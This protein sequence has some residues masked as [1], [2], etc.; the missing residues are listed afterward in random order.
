MMS[1]YFDEMTLVVERHGGMVAKFMG[2]A[3]LGVF[4]VPELHEDDALRAVRAAT[5]MRDALP[6]LNEELV[7]TW[8][9]NIAARTGVNTGEVMVADPARGESLLIGDAINLAARLEQTAATG[10]ILIG[11][12]TRRLVGEAVVAEPVGPL[13]LKGKSEPVLAWRV[14]EVVPEAPGWTR[15]LGSPLVG[16]EREVRCSARPLRKRSK[17]DRSSS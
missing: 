8:G 7:S 12:S 13:T 4:G 2:D 10:E 6:R 3:V 1:R 16:R 11:E 14:L 17:R 5:E 9:V 15:R